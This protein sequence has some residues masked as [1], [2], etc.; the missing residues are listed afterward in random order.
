M[1]APRSKLLGMRSPG[2]FH[3]TPWTSNWETTLTDFSNSMGLTI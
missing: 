2:I 1:E 3:P